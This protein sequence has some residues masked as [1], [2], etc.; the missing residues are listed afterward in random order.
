[1]SFLKYLILP[2]CLAACQIHM[3]WWDYP[4][5]FLGVALAGFPISEEA[6]SRSNEEIKVT[7]AVVM[8]YL[9]WPSHID[10]IKSIKPTLDN[11]WNN[12]S[13]PCMTWEPMTIHD[14]I[15]NAIP[16]SDIINGK[17]DSYLEWMTT[18][19]KSW[20]KPF[21]IRFAHEMNMSR[22]HWGTTLEE[23]GP[24]SPNV[25]ASMFQYVVTF[26]HNQNVDNV[27]WAFCPNADSIPNESWN[28]IKN[29]YPGDEYVDILGMD[30]YN[31][32]IDKDL[33]Q[34][35]GQTWTVPWRSFKEIF[36][37]P[38]RQLRQIAPNKPLIVF[39]TASV[40]RSSGDRKVKWMKEA[41]SIAKQWNIQGLIWFQAN[42]EEDWKIIQDSSISN[43]QQHADFQAWLVKNFKDFR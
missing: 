10:D 2:L 13:V 33:A 15:E 4:F 27:L 21:I 14:N 16:Y 22:Y 26:F 38:Y 20:G 32:D 42:K 36:E 18:E 12:K 43:E 8:F 30:G 29:Y 34:K 1:M 6:L 3:R 17:Y 7:P 35:K 19:I 5:P 37:L 24:S 31:W 25:Y 41:L 28:T 39:E 11:I 40:D 9:Q 23:Y